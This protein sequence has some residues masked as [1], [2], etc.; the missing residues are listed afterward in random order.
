[1]QNGF[2]TATE[3]ELIE[4][5]YPEC[6]NAYHYP[7]EIDPI[8]ESNYFA[9]HKE[10]AEKHFIEV[11]SREANNIIAE[12]I[13]AENWET[14]FGKPM[15]LPNGTLYH[16]KIIINADVRADQMKAFAKAHTVRA[17]VITFNMLG[18]RL[19]TAD[20]PTDGK[21]Y[22]ARKQNLNRLLF[23]IYKMNK[24]ENKPLCVIGRRKVDRGLGF[25]YAPRIRGP[26]TTTM[27]GKDGFLTTDG[28]EG[29]IW[30]NMI[31][32][33]KIDHT[34]TAVQKAGRGAGII[35]QCPQYPGKFHYWIDKETARAIEH[36]YKKVDAVN[37]LPGT[38]T[39]LQAVTHAEA[40]VPRIRQNHDVDMALFRVIRGAN[41][42]ETIELTKKI[43]T[44]VFHETFRLPEYDRARNQYKTSL[45]RTSDVVSLIDAIKKVPG[46]YGTRNQE[47][48][49]RR[50]L[51]CYLN[52]VDA[53]TLCCVI[54]LIDPS[55]T[56]AQ[57]EALETRYASKFLLCPQE[58]D[59]PH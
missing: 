2:V 23:Y 55:Y 48:K 16:H 22:S 18:V 12:R 41:K 59:M 40:I 32:G 53:N 36:H 45:N 19:Y 15:V 54:P 29:L 26:R 21:L 39:I 56:T 46:A 3:G 33:N 34:P 13:L 35:R 31:M 44:E 49:Y 5:E 4:E 7:V 42:A 52:V 51:P 30:T 47:K 24:L 10:G 14:H 37:E 11:H 50:F 58:G 8:D 43:V 57:K 9:F 1:M 17:H 6:A 25:H 38:N 28:I 27:E 20:G